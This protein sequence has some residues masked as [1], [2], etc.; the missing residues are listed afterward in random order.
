MQGNIKVKGNKTVAEEIQL[1]DTS[2]I[3]DKEFEDFALNHSKTGVTAFVNKMRTEATSE[4]QKKP[5]LKK[6][7]KAGIIPE[8]V[9]GLPNK[10]KAAT[11]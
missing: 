1:D 5:L 6:S 3:T 10:E 2:V 9:T 4:K 7:E 8:E 11:F